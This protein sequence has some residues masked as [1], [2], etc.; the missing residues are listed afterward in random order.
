MLYKI[1][2]WIC[3][4]NKKVKLYKIKPQKDNEVK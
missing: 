2:N 1:F 3:V 4:I